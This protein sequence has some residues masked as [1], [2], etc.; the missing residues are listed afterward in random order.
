[1][2][3]VFWAEVFRARPHGPYVSTCIPRQ[4]PL[5]PSTDGYQNG[6]TK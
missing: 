3:D 2:L 6:H 1:M 4:R 5:A